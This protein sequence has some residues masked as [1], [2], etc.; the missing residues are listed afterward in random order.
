MVITKVIVK[1]T[2]EVFIHITI[3]TKQM[4]IIPNIMKQQKPFWRA[5]ISYCC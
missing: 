2:I 4:L 5:P 1:I 3:G